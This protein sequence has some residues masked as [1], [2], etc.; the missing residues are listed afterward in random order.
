MGISRRFAIGAA[1]ATAV[2]LIAAATIYP[3]VEKQAAYA[4]VI[5]HSVTQGV[6]SE[7]LGASAETVRI[8]I[9]LPENPVLE[10]KDKSL[11]VKYTLVDASAVSPDETIDTLWSGSVDQM[12]AKAYGQYSANAALYTIEGVDDYYVAFVD[13]TTENGA[14]GNNGAMDWCFAWNDGDGHVIESACYDPATGIAYIPK[15]DFDAADVGVQIQL[16]KPINLDDTAEKVHVAIFSARDGFEA[17]MTEG[18]IELDSIEPALDIPVAAP[19]SAASITKGD[20]EVF[21]NDLYVALRDDNSSYDTETGILTV[22]I[23]GMGVTD[24]EVKVNAANSGLLDGVFDAR[25]A[26]GYTLY[27]SS[28]PYYRGGDTYF[29]KITSDQ[30]SPGTSF[31]YSATMCYRHGINASSGD[32]GMSTG[33][34]GGSTDEQ[35]NDIR[36]NSWSD[37]QDSPSPWYTVSSSV[38]R[39]MTMDGIFGKTVN[40]VNFHT[41]GGYST[42]LLECSHVSSPVGDVGYQPPGDSFTATAFMRVMK[43]VDNG[44]WSYI[45]AG[46]V[47][48]ETN[49]QTCSAV[50]KIRFKGGLKIELEKTSKGN[51]ALGIAAG[52]GVK[53]TYNV[54]SDAACTNKVSSIT[55]GDNGKGFTSVQDAGTYYLREASATWPHYVPASANNPVIA[56]S[57]QLGQTVKATAKD[58]TY[59][60]LQIQK[61][62][63]PP[64]GTLHVDDIKMG[65]NGT[66]DVSAKITGNRNIAYTVTVRGASGAGAVTLTLPSKVTYVDGIASPA[67]ISSNKKTITIPASATTSN[68]TVT[69]NAKI[70][71]GWDTSSGSTVSLLDVQT[72]R[73]AVSL[74]CAMST[75][76]LEGAEYTIYSNS[77]CTT[78]VGKVSIDADGKGRYG[79]EPGEKLVPGTK[80]YVKETRPA[81]YYDLDATVYDFIAATNVT[82]KETRLAVG[83][84]WH[85]LR[86]EKRS[87]YPDY[88]RSRSGF[89]LAGAVYE[90]WYDI[91]P[92]NLVDFAPNYTVTTDSNGNIN[93]PRVDTGN[94][95]IREKT[96]SLGYMA[97]PTW[98]TATVKN[99]EQAVVRVDEWVPVQLQIVKKSSSEVPNI[100]IYSLAGAEFTIY[101]SQA[102]ANAGTN[103][104][105]EIFE[106]TSTGR[107]QTQTLPMGNYWI[108][109]T[110]APDGFTK[111]NTVFKMT[112]AQFQENLSQTITV[113]ETP[114]KLT[115]NVTK[116]ASAATREVPIFNSLA[117]AKIAIYPTYADA[118][119]KT[120]AIATH[121]TAADGT[122]P[123]FEN[124][125]P[126]QQY[127]VRE[128]TA[129]ATY[130]INQNIYTVTFS[131]TLVKDVSISEVG[132]PVHI[133]ITKTVTG[134]NGQATPPIT[135]AVFGIYTS[136]TAAANRGDNYVAKVTCNSSG[137][138]S[139]VSNLPARRY[140]VSELSAPPGYYLTY[141]PVEAVFNDATTF[142]ADVTIA[143]EPILVE[144][145][146]AKRSADATATPA[147]NSS[148]FS[149]QNAKF[150]IYKTYAAALAATNSAQGSPIAVVTTNSSGLATWRGYQPPGIYYVKELVAPT[151]YTLA[152]GVYSVEAVEV[153]PSRGL[154]AQAAPI[155]DEAPSTTRLMMETEVFET[156][157]IK[158]SQVVYR[159]EDVVVTE[160]PAD[161]EVLDNIDALPVEQEDVF[162]ISDVEDGDAEMHETT[163]QEAAEAEAFSDVVAEPDVLDE[164]EAV[165]NEEVL[166]GDDGVV[167]PEPDVE[168]RAENA[169]TTGSAKNVVEVAAAAAE[170]VDLPSDEQFLSS[171]YTGMSVKVEEGA[172]P[173]DGRIKIAVIDTGVVDDC[174]A[175]RA[176]V[177]DDGV[178]GDCNGHGTQ[179]ASSI[180]SRNPNAYIISIRAFDNNGYAS[181]ESVYAAIKYAIEC[182]ADVINMSFAGPAAEGNTVIN[183][184]LWKASDAGA[185][186]VAAAGNYASDASCVVPAGIGCVV[187][188]GAL[189]EDGE[190]LADSNFGNC[191]RVWEIAPSTSMAAALVSGEASIDVLRFKEMYPAIL[192]GISPDLA[193]GDPGFETQATKDFAYTGGV[194]EFT[195]PWDGTYTLE[196]WGGAGGSY[197]SSSNFGGNG[198][199]SKGTVTLARNQK[200]YIVV[201]GKGETG[202]SSYSGMPQSAA[203]KGG[204]NGGGNGGLGTYYS[205]GS[206]SMWC[207]CAGGGG[208]ATHI[209]TTKRGSG[210]NAGLLKSYASYKSEVLIA[211]GGGGGAL[212][213]RTSTSNE[214]YNGEPGKGG[215]LESTGGTNHVNATTNPKATQT[216]GYAF[217]YGQNGRN[218]TNVGE[219]GEGNAGAGGGWY[220]GYSSQ[221]T[222]EFTQSP[223]G[224]GSGYIGGVSGGTSTT[225]GG[226]ANSNG[227]AKITWTPTQTV[228]FNANGGTGTMNNESFTMGTAKNLTANAFT[229]TAKVKYVYQDG[230]TA[231]RTVNV[232]RSFAGWAKSSGGAVTYS[233]KESVTNPAGNTMGATQ[234][235]YAKWNNA[236]VTLP[237]PTRTGWILNGWYT[238]SS[239]GTKRGAGGATYSFAPTLNST[240]TLYAQWKKNVYTVKFNGNGATSGTMAD[241]EMQVDIAAN[242]RSNT[243][244]KTGCTFLGW[245]L[246]KPATGTRVPHVDYTNGQSVK[247]LGTT[248]STVTLYAV[249]KGTIASAEDTTVYEAPATTS[250]RVV[251]TIS[252]TAN[253][254]QQ[255]DLT[256]AYSLKGAQFGVYTTKAAADAATTSSPGSP[257]AKITTDDS[258]TGIW[259]GAVV[260]TSYWLK[261]IKAPTG[262]KYTANTS[263]FA[264]GAIVNNVV[265]DVTV[266]ESLASPGTLK[267]NKTLGSGRA[268]LVTASGTWAVDGAKFGVYKSQDEAEDISSAPYVALTIADGT[269]SV[270][271]AP[272]TY[273]V[274]EISAPAGLA[275]DSTVKK[276][277]LTSGNTT[278]TSF[279]DTPL[280]IKI[281]IKKTN[282]STGTTSGSPFEYSLA[283]AVFTVYPTSTDAADGTNAVATMTTDAD[284]NASLDGLFPKVYYVKETT[285]PANFTRSTS[286]YVVANNVATAGVTVTV[287]EQPKAVYVR[288]QK[289]SDYDMSVF[290]T[291]TLKGA[292]FGIYSAASCADSTLLETITT[293]ASGYATS[294]ALIPGRYWVKETT[295]PTGFSLNT[296]VFEADLRSEKEAT[297]TVS[298]HLRRGKIS[299]TKATNHPEWVSSLAGVVFG[300]YSDDGCDNQ[301]ASMTT[302]ASGNAT[303]GDLRPGT[304]YVREDVGLAG[305]KMDPTV[306]TVSVTDGTTKAVNDGEPIVNETTSIRLM[307]TVSS[308]ITERYSLAGAVY[309]VFSDAS[310]DGQSQVGTIV[311][312]ENGMGSLEQIPPGEYYIKELVPPFGY[313][314]DD[315]V[316][317]I[318]AAADEISVAVVSD[319]IERL[320]GHPMPL[321]IIKCNDENGAVANGSVSVAGAEFTVCF[322]A[323]DLT[324]EQALAATPTRTWVLRTD[325]NGAA[326]FD[327]AH[328]VGGDDFY[329]DEQSGSIAILDGTML[330]A[331]TQAPVGYELSDG[332]WLFNIRE[333]QVFNSAGNEAAS[334]TVNVPETPKR[335]NV[336][337]AKT[338]ENGTPMANMPFMISL[339]DGSDVVEEHLVFTDANG[340][341]DSSAFVGYTAVNANDGLVFAS[342]D[343]TYVPGTDG[344]VDENRLWFSG[345]ANAIAEPLEGRGALVY[346]T[347]RVCE[348][349]SPDNARYELPGPI[350]F[351]VDDEH[352]GTIDIG[353]FVNTDIEITSTSAID[354]TT[355]SHSGSLNSDAIV[356]TVAYDGLIVGQTYTFIGGAYDVETGNPIILDDTTGLSC[357]VTLTAAQSSGTLE[358]TYP[359]AGF[360]IAGRKVGIKTRV[361]RDFQVKAVHNDDLS[362]AEQTVSYP[363]IGTTATDSNGTHTGFTGETVTINDDVSYENLDPGRTYTL[364]GSVHKVNLASW[365]SGTTITGTETA[366]FGSSGV[367]HAVSGDLYLNTLS[368]DVYRCTV[369]GTPASATWAYVGN[370]VPAGSP[371]GASWHMGT[372]VSHASG[373]M[374]ADTGIAS[375]AA[376]DL[377]LNEKTGSIYICRI[378][379]PSGEATWEKADVSA[380]VAITDAG[381]LQ[382]SEGAPVT[383]E[384]T[385]EPIS[386]D[387]TANMSFAFANANR[388]IGAVV[389][390]EE[391]YDS[392]GIL[393]SAHSDVFDEGQTV[394]YPRASTVAR[395]ATTSGHQGVFVADKGTIID[396]VT[397]ENLEPGVTYTLTG[398][399]VDAETGEAIGSPA[400]T[401]SATFTPIHINGTVEMTFSDIPKEALTGKLTVVY[402]RVFNGTELVAEHADR[403][404]TDQQVGYPGLHT[405]AIDAASEQHIGFIEN[406]PINIID[407]V[408]YSGLVP[409][410]E[411]TVTGIVMSKES[412]QPLKG[413]S[414]QDITATKTFTPE[415]ANGEIALSFAV[416]RSQTA[417]TAVV[418][419]ELTMGSVLVGE[420]KDIGD[421]AQSVHYPVIGTT[422]TDNDTQDHEGA[423]DGTITITDVVNYTNLVPGQPYT[424]TGALMDKATGTAVK[425]DADNEVTATTT[426]T[427]QTANGTVNVVF[428]FNKATTENLTYVAYE[429][430]YSASSKIAEHNDL[431]DEQQSIFFPKIRTTAT[432]KNT[433][434][435]VGS[436]EANGK[437]TLVDVVSYDNLIVGHEYTITGKLM[438]GETG[439]ALKSGSTEVTATKTFMAAA[440]SGTETLEF[441][442]DQ[443]LVDSGTHVVAF[444]HLW[445]NGYE[446]ATHAN[447]EDQDQT[448]WYPHISTTAKDKDLGIKVGKLNGTITV[449]DTVAYEDLVPN[450]AYTLTA[451]LYSKGSGDLLKNGSAPVTGAVTFTPTAAFGTQ[452]V[453]ITFPAT[454]L[455]QGGILVAY[456]ELTH[457]SKPV[458]EHT[459]ANDDAQTVYYP[460][461]GTTAL[462]QT[463]NA[464][465]GTVS[466]ETTVITDTIAYENLMPGVAY[467]ID[468]VLHDKDSGAVIASSVPDSEQTFTPQSPSGTVTVHLTVSSDDVAGR[469]AVVFEKVFLDDAEVAVHE[470]IDDDAQSM[471]YPKVGTTATDFVTGTH[472]GLADGTVKIN[473]AVAYEN[474]IPDNT[475]KLIGTLYY[476]DSGQPVKDGDDPITTAKTFTPVQAASTEMLTLSTPAALVDGQKT[477]VFEELYNADDISVAEH[478]QRYDD[479]QTVIYPHIHTTALATTVSS[480]GTVSQGREIPA[481]RHVDLADTLTYRNLTPGQTYTVT[482]TIVVKDSETA[483]KDA[484]NRVIEKTST[485]K[486]ESADG[487]FEVVF[488]EI[489]AFHNENVEIV[490]YEKVYNGSALVGQHTDIS[491]AAQ[492]IKFTRATDVVELPSSGSS[493]LGIW[494]IAGGVFTASAITAACLIVLRRRAGEEQ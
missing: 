9:V 274:R 12:A 472:E 231:D 308:D 419:E 393:V 288:L 246:T 85:G 292:K 420:H 52:T 413:A 318:G 243:F 363:K 215:G 57:G 392:D 366:S 165:I 44:D 357:V 160:V 438:D 253:L 333:G 151:G 180:L 470:D 445:R 464:H 187:T 423:N 224:G 463:T 488:P 167:L 442:F 435:H 429:T 441:T 68:R 416:P 67:T 188:V 474:L 30:V 98:Y 122:C 421:E 60:Q 62:K 64:S 347:Y 104:L 155:V 29:D 311:T 36:W 361:E 452:D 175:M 15:A 197:Y 381:V 49:S 483:F 182:G 252:N 306:Y 475:Y 225:G 275:L 307:K 123:P 336:R 455:P 295:A 418:Y 486:P 359:L 138:C 46:F 92:R 276:V 269:A 150:G 280:M 229:F 489:D 312:D 108:K 51:N 38:S 328:K 111:N 287:P 302:D 337:F 193:E 346:G 242:L 101:G 440:A 163:P 259:T 478:K 314:L 374:A 430:L 75:A 178:F 304:Y 24:V 451:T 34:A 395:D 70:P 82:A 370:V 159:D 10:Q 485:F 5:G 461:I 202:K 450:T 406:D 45:I 110:K 343:K 95:W 14:A 360:D 148:L 213:C 349:E 479:G 39:M 140:W 18:E 129:P 53:A 345:D 228:K 113:P 330:I 258:G 491:D 415:N 432:D 352:D 25:E 55:T 487:E 144:M 469:N 454:L 277:T 372:A 453:E 251:K 120:N 114:R 65:G 371:A 48:P 388:N 329:Y 490:V 283:G 20:L 325:E 272:G 22:N 61:Y 8:P 41:V 78:V 255:A 23:N 164:P 76:T 84:S 473:D 477:V 459:D 400:V 105:F 149:Y 208:G 289:T 102:D 132:H 493:T 177:L 19:S 195:A 273:W 173:A 200:L 63:L 471:S 77:A 480:T 425:D 260:G 375:P 198:G 221:K 183:D 17:A 203:P 433:Q 313:E 439:L 103:P 156:I 125:P 227:K 316:T 112:A 427:P 262:G 211:A 226:V 93:L 482:S 126:Q 176:T 410:T 115:V 462:D 127:F 16:M 414:N 166:Y 31:T 107:S 154:M 119:A 237:N 179:V 27:E 383:A 484:Q 326:V 248:D 42:L 267:I 434:D 6:L 321:Q 265:K 97:N 145:R 399:L 446:I 365:Y 282:A 465:E 43:T 83:D 87:Q 264:T 86:I 137:V 158:D 217:G 196:V 331:E 268:T 89:S 121:T 212:P 168:V 335:S 223:G 466:P 239:G 367:E 143:E 301:V 402:E 249:W 58:D 133:K 407:T 147:T 186:L 396:T 54:Y 219:G 204:Y 394:Y 342:S 216:S 355:D 303:S 373:R 171:L 468:T 447:L 116:T 131:T 250:I 96:A 35:T 172:E 2:T 100:S 339:M 327:E 444:E 481:N 81:A 134:N 109:E 136:K 124:L 205:W 157:D 460:N 296:T 11:L 191:V 284:G 340:V 32:Y 382:S 33:L 285:A 141:D 3:S 99:N 28:I 291:L 380:P 79:Y 437:T 244:A 236:S 281:N 40:G 341:F 362:N 412:G 350:T 494:Q 247:N 428:T 185:A 139:Q 233:N 317:P 492:T 199:Y 411:Y 80:Y 170:A 257:V 162:K 181:T 322:Y 476:R 210:S 422:A 146:I 385:F 397:Y 230:S 458:A 443:T 130:Q 290:P 88:T 26:Y 153:E 351:T 391:L 310:C 424:M 358:M 209:A 1:A 386:A 356:D 294:H 348:L 72:S 278:T 206:G 152:P 94:Y 184:I 323:E 142:R 207:W 4:P 401:A 91:D 309:G 261:E 449:T 201:G 245:S 286:T 240:T 299:A 232:T 117:G 194:Q 90:I 189:G 324:E 297:I 389:V 417:F 405:T 332:R 190:P 71:V 235:L 169:G 467:R 174:A 378:G 218:G 448:I 457:A 379:E 376:G 338:D 214:N 106:T 436:I 238:A 220:G 431:T 21:A 241:Q 344:K 74:T 305:H 118:Q 59:S 387:G 47:S 13:A 69:F 334:M 390:F 408:H 377:Y 320:L 398:V 37:L 404:D 135:G 354:S 426:F 409:G 270:K 234:T 254:P 161:A 298:D 128:V 271:L 279:A 266:S 300:I 263:T 293:D 56:V 192:D 315:M 369:G 73:L 7:R 403:S 222:G 319:D 368:G 256:G 456:E 353:T 50:Y 384:Q 364:R 66:V